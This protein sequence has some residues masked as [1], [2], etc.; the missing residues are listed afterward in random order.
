[1]SKNKRIAVIEY[2]NKIITLLENKI[3]T[4]IITQIKQ[5]DS[6]R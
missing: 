4:D 2:Q 1:M 5:T 6:K 3:I